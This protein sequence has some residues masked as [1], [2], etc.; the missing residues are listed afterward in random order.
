MS[1]PVEATVE[2]ASVP[3]I[4]KPQPEVSPL[5][6][7]VTKV[8]PQLTFDPVAL[9]AKYAEEREKRLRWN[10]GVEQYRHIDDKFQSLL[11]DPYVEKRLERDPV[12]ES[13]EVVII[14]GGYGA[15]LIAVSLLEQGITDFRIIEKGAE[16]GGTWYWNRYPGAQ[17]DIES[18]VYMPLLSETGYVPTW[19]YAG[20]AELID[21]ARRIGRKYG[22]YEKAL[23]QTEVQ[24]MRWKEDSATW[25]V[26]TDRK[27]SISAR[28][29]IPAAG[30]LHR[31]KL[32]D[33]PG[34]GTFKGHAFHTSR[35]DYKYTG[36]DQSGDLQGLADKRVGVIGTGAT[37][38]QIVPHLGAAAK[39]LFV[40]Q[41]TP[42]SIDVRGNKPTDLEW[43]KTLGANWQKERMDNFN[44][45]VNGGSQK[46][47][48]VADGWTDIFRRLAGRVMEAA[49][50]G[51]GKPDMAKLAETRQLFD[52][53]KMNQVRERCDE[54]VADKETAEKLK[55]YYN[56]FCKRP[57]FHDEY[58]PTFNRP[59]VKLVDTDGRGVERITE[60]GVIANG[61]E[62]ELDCLIYATGFELATDFSSKTGIEI[63]GR[64]GVTLTEKWQDGPSTLHGLTS[65]A[66]PNC[67][68]VSIVQAALSPNFLHIT[69]EQAK[70]IAYIISRCQERGIRTLEPTQEAEDAWVRTIID[71][72]ARRRAF[73]AS[74]TPGYY[75]NEGRSSERSQKAGFAWRRG[76]GVHED[77]P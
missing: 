6:A 69:A 75:N 27:D 74:C 41:R 65:R 55:P 53:E 10:K 49:A 50:A 16:F 12:Q 26:V 67:F 61:K 7:D 28:F 24:A 60:A 71:S 2:Q 20:G 66:F 37:S 23:L 9:R 68:F 13:C 57:C 40:F 47:D 5:N 73:Q 48:L 51:G 18:Y 14:G 30:P 35:W 3:E 4:L 22:L 33:L 17:C 21:H 42:S 52:F 58:L 39:Q 34:L 62:Y 76:A 38:V 46:E 29:V 15:Q 1:A 25:E 64:G 77:H 19:K 36:G 45:F 31:P 43:V 56:Q 70:H 59:S 32:P 72:G 8:D 11:D 44:V 63:F 54:V